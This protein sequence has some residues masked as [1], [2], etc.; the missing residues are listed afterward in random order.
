LHSNF[1]IFL[2]FGVIL[3]EPSLT[4]VR[5]NG[6]I[7]GMLKL[8]ITILLAVIMCLSPISGLFAVICHGSDGHIAVEPVFHSHCDCPQMPEASYNHAHTGA[9]IGS[10]AD[11]DHC[12]DFTTFSSVILPGK[13]VKPSPVKVLTA[14]YLQNTFLFQGRSF[15]SCLTAQSGELCP[16]F[17]PL[18]T[19]ILL[20]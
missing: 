8:N 1:V 5:K 20:S 13:T 9:T 14:S 12:R 4:F 19:V 18:R 11:H 6:K 3:S 7:C 16:F 2:G 17:T 10:S 15:L